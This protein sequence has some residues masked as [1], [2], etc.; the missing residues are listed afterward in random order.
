MVETQNMSRCTEIQERFP[1]LIAA[2]VKAHKIQ[3][4]GQPKVGEK[5]K[6]VAQSRKK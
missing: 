2:I 3:L 4:K 1:G 6:S 5:R